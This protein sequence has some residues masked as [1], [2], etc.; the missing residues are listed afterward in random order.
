MRFVTHALQMPLPQTHKIRVR[1]ETK[2]EVD[3]EGNEREVDAMRD[4]LR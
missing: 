3:S 2:V 4:Q 1:K